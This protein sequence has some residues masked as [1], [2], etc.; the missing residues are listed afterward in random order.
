[1]VETGAAEMR[2]DVTVYAIEHPQK[3]QQKEGAATWNFS[4]I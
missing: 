2:S 3:T 1:M 4:P